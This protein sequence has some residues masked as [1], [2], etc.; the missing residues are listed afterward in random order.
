MSVNEFMPSP[1]LPQAVRALQD[2]DCDVFVLPAQEHDLDCAQCGR[3][4]TR[5]PY[6]DGTLCQTGRLLSRRAWRF[7]ALKDAA[8]DL[9]LEIEEMSAE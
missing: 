9:M 6:R 3:V 1:L 7:I 8:T 2:I 4:R 5:G